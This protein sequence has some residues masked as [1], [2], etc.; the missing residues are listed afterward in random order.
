[1]MKKNKLIPYIY[2]GLFLFV[3]LIILLENSYL[4]IDQTS[5]N[6]TETSWLDAE[7]LI[8]SI[9][10]GAKQSIDSVQLTE[11]QVQRHIKKIAGM[12]DRLYIEADAK[13]EEEFK[14]ILKNYKII[15]FSIH[16]GKGNLLYALNLDDLPPELQKTDTLAFPSPKKPDP[17]DRSSGNSRVMN[18]LKT[19]MADSTRNLQMLTIPRIVSPLSPSANPGFIHIYFGDEK[20]E[21]VRARIGL[22]LLINSLENQNVIQH[23]SFMNDQLMIIADYEPSRV[24]TLDEKLDNLDALNKGLTYKYYNQTNETQ[25]FVHSIQ[26]TPDTRGVFRVTFR[27]TG[28]KQIYSNTS[29]ITIINS[30]II[31]VMASI[32][33]MIML[34]FHRRNINRMDAMEKKI[35]ENEKLVSLANLTAGVAHEV[36]NPLNSIS[37][38]I[39]RLQMEFTPRN[40]ADEDEYIMLTAT[41]KNEVDRINAII[42]DF[43]DFAKP[44]KPN[45]TFFDLED[46]IEENISF[47]SAEAQKTNIQIHKFVSASQTLFLGDREKLTQVL[48][49]LFF[50][51]LEATPQGGTISIYSDITKDKNWQLKIEDTGEGISDQNF[52]HIFDIYFTTKKTGTG[53]GLYICRKII[54]AHD[55]SIELRPNPTRGMTAIVTL[56]IK[57]S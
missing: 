24:G 32:S 29:K 42:T 43:L 38:T 6:I 15:A 10:A 16:N 45:D 44:F 18:Q 14:D 35:R 5:T 20:L 17:D 34:I 53:L 28:L 40:K 39:Q 47:L 37:I 48:L 33:A 23:V 12:I 27:M 56:P 2:V 51:A 22:Q 57:S 31:M 49:N 36:R 26:L 3:I 55:G 41:M 13:A 52:K 8:Y 9:I 7:K 25:T 54:Q 46:F 11:Q 19:D 1:M 21:E 30:I 50:N 4:L